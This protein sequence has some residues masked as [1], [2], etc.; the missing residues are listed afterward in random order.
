MVKKMKNPHAISDH[1]Q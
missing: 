1:H